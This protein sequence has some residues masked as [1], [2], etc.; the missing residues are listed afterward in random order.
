MVL[1]LR[2]LRLG[3]LVMSRQE[4]S[5][6]AEEAVQAMIE[7]IR[8][9]GRGALPWTADADNL[10]Q[11]SEWLRA[12]G[13]ADDEWP[14]LSD[15][16]LLV[17]LNEWLAP[18]LG[19]IRSRSQLQQLNMAAALKSM[20]TRPQLLRLDELAPVAL[21]VPTGSRIRLDYASGQSPVLPV[22]LQEMLG[23]SDTPRVAGGKV[24]VLIHLLSPAGRPLAVT[25]DLRSFWT[26]S[27][28]EVRKQMRGRYPKHEWPED[29]SKAAP[30]RTT[31][32]R[33]NRR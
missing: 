28:P 3:A 10:Q 26:N 24:P 17:T 20:F 32:R 29:P 31:K 19:G 8:L 14:D 5:P 2:T 30:T 22:R 1:G 15:Q 4:F 6:P 7:G 16:H 33:G 21:I 13:P 9:M 18:F 23:E 25:Q 11:R 27:Y 12:R